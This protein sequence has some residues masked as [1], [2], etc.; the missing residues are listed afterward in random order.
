[1]TDRTDCVYY[2]VRGKNDE[3]YCTAY[4]KVTDEHYCNKCQDYE[5]K[6]GL[7]WVV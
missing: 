6:R 2:T 5:Q 4:G 1:M 7:E 3:S